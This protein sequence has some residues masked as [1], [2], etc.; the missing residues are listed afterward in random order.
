MNNTITLPTLKPIHLQRTFC[1]ALPKILGCKDYSDQ[2]ELIVKM[3]RELT[4]SGVED[5]F[6]KLSLERY[7]AEKRDTMDE[8]CRVRFAQ[9]SIRALRC[10]V[11]RNLLGESLRGM[12]R[13][14]AECP[15]YQKFCG[16]NDFELTRI[17]SKS[18]LQSYEHW[19]SEDKM[20]FILHA[21]REAVSNEEKA[22]SIGLKKTIQMNTVIVDTTCLEA[23][24][25]FP[26]DWVLLRDVV[27]TLMKATACI[28]RHGLKERMIDPM[29][30]LSRINKECIAMSAKQ[31]KK[32]GNK[33][34]RRRKKGAS[35]AQKDVLRKM[36]NIVN[37]V[38]EHALRHRNLLD[39]EWGQTDLTRAEAEVIINRIDSIIAQIPEAKHQAHERIIGGR[40][41]PPDKKI[42]S[43]YDRDIRI[44]VKGKAG[45][46]AEFGNILFLAQQDLGYIIDHELL[47]ETSPGDIQL[48]LK[49]YDKLKEATGNR[50]ATLSADRGFDAKSTRNLLKKDGVYNVICPK[51]PKELSRRIKEEPKFKKTLKNR[52]CI[53][54][55]ISILKNVFLWETPKAKGYENR[56]MQVTWAVL[57][58]NLWVIAR[59]ARWKE[60]CELAPLAG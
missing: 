1:Q 40:Q 27:R 32:N 31:R 46:R 49:R 36:K 10:T 38:E 35:K 55:R 58:H 28:R 8:W 51:D 57:S 9:H 25:H 20:L 33:S 60:D 39:Q 48:L 17:P 19:L 22:K 53:E 30:F 43:L 44:S 7:D 16:L 13:R 42:F 56:S 45:A 23:N 6:L 11:L 12:S 37:I 3:D 18:T 24:I 50:L 26:V 59:K 14:L 41:V 21:L 34:G 47:K 2:E 4:K 15:L 52:G 5:L 54:G 29:L